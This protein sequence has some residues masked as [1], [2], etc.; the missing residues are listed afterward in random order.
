[1]YT[2]LHIFGKFGFEKWEEIDSMYLERDVRS[3]ERNTFFFLMADILSKF[4][5]SLK[6]SS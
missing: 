4:T 2:Q 6:G 3:S 5:N 1:M